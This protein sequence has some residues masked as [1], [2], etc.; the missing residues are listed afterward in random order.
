MHRT[1]DEFLA[2]AGLSAHGHC[3]VRLGDFPDNAKHFLER[4]ARPDDSGEVVNPALCLAQTINLV[5]YMAHFKRLQH[6]DLH[7]FDFEG[8]LY[9][10][11]G[12]RLHGFY[13]Y[14]N[15]PERGHHDYRRGGMECLG[16]FQHLEAGAAAHLEIA[17][18]DVEE[19][20]M[21]L[22]DGY[23]AIRSFFG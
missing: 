17:Q 14:R 7:L 16:S 6:L 12:A 2:R 8:L 23:I 13:S 10:V 11:E 1:S 3:R 22:L 18:D 15:R 19:P 21:K 20:F 4:A 9:E 5:L